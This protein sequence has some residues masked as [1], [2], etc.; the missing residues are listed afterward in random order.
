[1]KSAPSSLARKNRAR[2]KSAFLKTAPLRSAL[3]KSASES[4][5]DELGARPDGAGEIRLFEICPLERR[6]T[7]FR[8][9][10]SGF[11]HVALVEHAAVPFDA[12]RGRVST[13]RRSG[14]GETDKEEDYGPHQHPTAII[15]VAAPPIKRPI[16]V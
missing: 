15:L 2:R 11:R 12:G 1:M 13:E 16:C 6:R 4:G 9:G 8:T 3:V 5:R 14:T 10:Q 7:D